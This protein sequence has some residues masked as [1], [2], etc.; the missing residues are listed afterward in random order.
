MATQA[1]RR[2]Q[3]RQKL[4][5]AA[6]ALFER[7]GFDITSVDQIVAEANVAK[8]TFYQ[9]FEAK[10][11]VL[12]AIE[13]EAGAKPINEALA[14]VAAG[15]PAWPILEAYLDHLAEFF[16]ARE[17]IAEAI[18]LSSLRT[19]GDDNAERAQPS[20]RDFIASL[21][22]AAQQQG[23]IRADM[24][25]GELGLQIG[26][27][28][29]MTVL[30]WSRNPRPHVLKASFKRSLKLFLEGAQNHEQMS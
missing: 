22:Q 28:I 6:K 9:Y 11:D 30:A 1:E 19:V 8:G 29:T 7:Q 17:K 12:M 15:A 5:A 2:A 27:F 16:E 3:T 13:R 4:M 18:V 24:K 21:L 20:G 14:Q 23:A 26:G 10:L 25:L